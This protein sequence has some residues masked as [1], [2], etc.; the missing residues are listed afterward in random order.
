MVERNTTLTAELHDTSDSQDGLTAHINV[1]EDGEWIGDF[2]AEFTHYRDDRYTADWSDVK[3]GN[4][5][6]VD[7]HPTFW[8]VQEIVSEL[9]ETHD[10]MEFKAIDSG[11]NDR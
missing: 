2:F 5:V 9:N 10:D 8:P 7:G 6:Y 4:G 1:L 3:R 11:P